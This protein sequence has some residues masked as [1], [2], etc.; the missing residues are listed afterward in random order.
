MNTLLIA[1][2]NTGK[3]REIAAL[4]TELPLALK[5]L[6]DFPH[7]S[8]AVDEN[9]TTF[10]ENAEIKARAYFDELHLT[11]AAEDSG[12][13]VDVLNG[14]PGVHSARWMTGSDEDRC[15]GLLDKLT[16][17]EN[18][19]ARFVANVCLIDQPSK[20][21]LHVEGVVTGMIA[22]N[23]RGTTGFGFDPIFI[24]DGYTQTNA[25]LGMAVKN[26]ISARAQAWTQLKQYLLAA[27]STRDKLTTSG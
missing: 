22:Q 1:T 24:P 19:K 21:C 27:E 26:Q 18:R 11:T 3:V 9:G 2:T 25:E 5:F 13:E 17:I 12:L 4:L 23:L 16:G 8:V 14:F 15:R 7:Q 6:G 20:H 10:A